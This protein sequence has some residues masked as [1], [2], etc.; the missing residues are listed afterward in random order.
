MYM[1][2]STLISSTLSNCDQTV[3][4]LFSRLLPSTER[5]SHRV[6]LVTF[7]TVKLAIANQGQ[8]LARFES[9]YDMHIDELL[10]SRFVRGREVTLPQSPTSDSLRIPIT[11]YS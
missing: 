3:R 10:G 1:A 5:R 8:L 4:I 6:T 7:V 11:S 2:S 9:L